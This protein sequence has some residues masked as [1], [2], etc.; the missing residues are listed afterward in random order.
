M[1]QSTQM[2]L[3]MKHVLCAIQGPFIPALPPTGVTCHAHTFA[4]NLEAAG[5]PLNTVSQVIL[6]SWPV[7]ASHTVPGGHPM[8]RKRLRLNTTNPSLTHPAHFNTP[9]TAFQTMRHHLIAVKKINVVAKICCC[10]DSE[11][12]LGLP[13]HSSGEDTEARRVCPTSMSW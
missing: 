9:N 6:A 7:G 11:D 2:C 12:N 8:M 1:Q 5:K 13:S 4:L 10:Q 3:S